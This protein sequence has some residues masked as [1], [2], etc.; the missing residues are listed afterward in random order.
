MFYDTKKGVYRFNITNFKETLSVIYEGKIPK[1]F[2]EGENI[3][4]TGYFTD[5]E[6]KFEI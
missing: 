6:N 3:I 2:S 4:L 5:I 1:E